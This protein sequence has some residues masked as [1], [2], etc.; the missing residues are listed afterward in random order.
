MKKSRF[1]IKVYFHA[2][3][4]KVLNYKLLKVFPISI[5]WG[6]ADSNSR[7]NFTKKMAIKFLERHIEDNDTVKII[8][9]GE[10]TGL[11]YQIDYGD[12]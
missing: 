8:P 1:V 9:S 3:T 10:C 12:Y 11:S 2:Q 6:Q 4:G 7:V 5:Q